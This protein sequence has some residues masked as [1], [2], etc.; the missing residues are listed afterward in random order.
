MDL[1]TGRYTLLKSMN[2]ICQHLL[3][4]LVIRI[5][6]DYG[7]CVC[8]YLFFFLHSYVRSKLVNQYLADFSFNISTSWYP[9]QLL[10][11]NNLLTQFSIQKTMK[12]LSSINKS[13]II[14][15]SL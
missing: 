4:M 5:D 14:H 15:I 10:L 11:T 7:V 6:T 1:N 3:L 12:K 13:K 8:V 2:N 9:L